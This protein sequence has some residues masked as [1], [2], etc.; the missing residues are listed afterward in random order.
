MLSLFLQ[1]LLTASFRCGAI[2]MVGRLS[3]ES[4]TRFV[5]RD[6]F[7]TLELLH[8]RWRLL[9]VLLLCGHKVECRRALITALHET[10]ILG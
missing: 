6:E 2:A 7:V 3:L 10:C 5:I 8:W 4:G 1:R 9:R